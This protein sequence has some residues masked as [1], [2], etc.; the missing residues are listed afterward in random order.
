V[1]ELF[2]ILLLFALDGLKTLLFCFSSATFRGQPAAKYHQRTGSSL[3]RVGRLPD[4][5]HGLQVNS[6]VSLP[7]SH[8]SSHEP[9]TGVE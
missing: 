6:L 1:C 4:L 3:C 7:V 8:K 2:L 5:K 9:L